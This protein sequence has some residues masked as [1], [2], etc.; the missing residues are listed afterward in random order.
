MDLRQL[1][2]LVVATPPERWHVVPW[3]QHAPTMTILARKKSGKSR[4]V[5]VDTHRFLAVHHEHPD[6]SLAWGM[7]QYRR[8]WFDGL[9]FPKRAVRPKRR[10]RKVGSYFADVQLAG[11]PVHRE[12]LLVVD[13]GRAH[14]PFPDPLRVDDDRVRGATIDRAVTE[15]Q[16]DF[17][18]LL[19]SLAGRASRFDSYFESSRFVV[20]AGHPLDGEAPSAPPVP[21]PVDSPPPPPTN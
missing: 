19:D 13:R 4:E 15:W 20:A 6:L 21:P 8:L 11:N 2:D 14:L 1:L 16:H 7:T 17:A 5:I 18:K 9:R 3:A 10:T 12:R